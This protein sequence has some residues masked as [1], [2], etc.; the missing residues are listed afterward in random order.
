[1]TDRLLPAMTDEQLDR[2]IDQLFEERAEDVALIALPADAMAERIATRLR[3][4]YGVRNGFALVGA[5]LL[6][7]AALAAAAVIG[8]RPAPLLLVTPVTF[9]CEAATPE[10]TGQQVEQMAIRDETGIVSGCRGVNADEAAALRETFGPPLPDFLDGNSVEITK[11]RADSTHLLVLWVV[12]SC[13][14]TA[15]IDLT[16]DASTRIDLVVAQPR[17]GE[18]PGGTGLGAVEISTNQPISPG[19][20]S[21]RVIRDQSGP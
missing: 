15:R 1:M 12:A 17:A 20:A 11:S 9:E 18:C 6:L 7:L 8:S 14:G 21:G 2:L 10:F 3:P 5:L 4:A 16:G 13:D 19:N